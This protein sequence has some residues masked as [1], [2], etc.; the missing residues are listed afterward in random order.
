ML[1]HDPTCSLRVV[2]GNLPGDLPMEGKGFLPQLRSH[3]P[4]DLEQLAAHQHAEGIHQLL[5]QPVFRHRGHLLVEFVVNVSEL[6]RVRGCLVQKR[7]EPEIDFVEDSG[8]FG[9]A[10][11]G[12]VADRF[13]LQCLPQFEQF[14]IGNPLKEKHREQRKV[15][16]AVL[17]L[18]DEN[19]P[20]RG[21]GGD[22][23]KFQNPQRLPQS[24]TADPEHGHQL[25][26][27]IKPV[28]VFQLP[29]R[30]QADDG[31]DDGTVGFLGTDR[32]EGDVHQPSLPSRTDTARVA[33]TS[34]PRPSRS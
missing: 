2:Q 12:G 10:A 21:D 32:G 20:A 13:D 16:F 33:M 18:V 19:S 34:T 9:A 31:A 14:A 27:V 26:L 1:P 23:E 29:P 5:S 28:A 15:S 7:F 22:A 30:D 8:L 24:R 3:C 4:T 11:F 25:L 6:Y 17:R